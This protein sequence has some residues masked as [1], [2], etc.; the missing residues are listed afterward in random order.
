ME[1]IK[2]ELYFG[3]FL[4]LNLNMRYRHHLLTVF[5]LLTSHFLFANLTIYKNGSSLIT[6]TW[7][8]QSPSVLTSTSVDSPYEGSE[9][10]RFTYTTSGTWAGIGLNLD[11]W[12]TGAA[13]DFS[14]Y[15][16]LRIAYRGLGAGHALSLNFRNGNNFGAK[17]S[18]GGSTGAYTIVNIPVTSLVNVNNLL[19]TGIREINMEVTSPGAVE[20]S[21]V[22]IDALELINITAPAPIANATCLSRAA[23]LGKGF[24]TSNWLEAWWRISSNSY[25][26]P[27]DYTRARFKAL[28]DA[29]F[30]H[31]RLPILFEIISQDIPPYKLNTTHLAMQL[32]DSAIVWSNAFNLKLIIDNH[33]GHSITDANYQTEK[34][35]KC[36]LWRQIVQRYGNLD[37]NRF[38]FEIYNEPNGISNANWRNVAQAV[39]DTVR[40]I[41]TTH[42]FIIGGNGW[43]SMNG[44]VGFEPLSDPNVIYTYHNYEPYF[45]THQGMTW[46]SPPNFASRDFPLGNEKN[47]LR[48]LFTS[49]KQWSDFYGVPTY[50][51]EFGVSYSAPATSRCEWVS[52]NTHLAD[53]LGMP[54]AYWDAK[55]YNDAFGFFPGGISETNVI[56]CFKTAMNLYATPLSVRDITAMKAQCSQQN[57]DIQWFSEVDD[58]AGLFIIEISTDGFNWQE[59]GE[60]KARSG[61]NWYKKRIELTQKQQYYRVVHLALDGSKTTSA[62]FSTNCKE[63]ISLA[64]YPNPVSNTDLNVAFSWGQ[65]QN[66]KIQLINAH[67]QVVYRK[68]YQALDDENNTTIDVSVYPKG[69]YFLQLW[70]ENNESI[71]TKVTID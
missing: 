56:P 49:V 36:A 33:H 51:G 50:M 47:E 66:I 14:G 20:S 48:G 38:F 17:I 53:S 16:H 5:S 11:N 61:A 57:V 3:L 28:K 21:I 18:V 25:P 54:Y 46:T 37:P 29:G 15:T 41:N 67:G 71:S 6:G 40:A 43:N 34:L 31:V 39:M 12:G 30:T 52:L 8:A 65:A 32:V 13:K 63:R 68:S 7:A 35:R 19:I 24:N 10:Y 69:L 60:I 58:V 55:N 42:T 44:L 45:F 64:V 9:H 22:Y 23:S 59:Q 1:F 26:D 4:N 70:S 62:V 2:K 27:A